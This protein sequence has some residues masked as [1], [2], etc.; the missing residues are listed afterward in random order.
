[1]PGP[2]YILVAL[3]IHDRTGYER[4]VRAFVP[5]FLAR[6]GEILAVQDE[7]VPVEGSW[8]FSRVV[9]L[10]MPSREAFETWYRSD[11]Y[12]AIAQDRFNSA[13]ANITVLPEFRMA[14]LTLD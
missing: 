4:Y 2:A 14:G 13:V 10:R 6:G 8:P 9:I 7:P 12:Q 1:M 11:E 3:A 5:A